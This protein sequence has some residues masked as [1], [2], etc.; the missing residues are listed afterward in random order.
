MEEADAAATDDTSAGPRTKTSCETM[1]KQSPEGKD[2]HP[3]AFIVTPPSNNLHATHG[4]FLV[5][6]VGNGIVKEVIHR[7]IFY[8]SWRQRCLGA[9]P[10]SIGV[11]G[12]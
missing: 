10:K 4:V 2:T 6:N 11:V 3:L 8:A 9:P 7:E 12:H 1:S 5:A